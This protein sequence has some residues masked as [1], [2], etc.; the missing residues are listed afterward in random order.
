MSPAERA[1]SAL[2]SFPPGGSHAENTKLGASFK[3]AGGEFADFDAWRAQDAESQGSTYNRAQWRSYDGL[4]VGAGLLFHLATQENDWRDPDPPPSHTNGTG[5]AHTA[6]RDADR[7]APDEDTGERALDLWL[8]GRPAHEHPYVTRKGL[9]AA[10]DADRLR[11]A[12]HDPDCLLVPIRALSDA[13]P[14]VAV[15]RIFA[16]GTKRTLGKLTPFPGC[17]YVIGELRDGV[18]VLACEGMAT[19]E[20]V[21]WA[22]PAAV[23]V[24]TVGVGRVR[25][26]MTEVRERYP[27]SPRVIVADRGRHACDA[28]REKPAD[29]IETLIARAAQE[30]RSAWVSMPAEAAE[31]YDAW[32]FATERGP[33]AL[34]VWIADGGR[35]PYKPRYTGLLPDTV[36]AQPVMHDL[37]DDVIPARSVG[38]IWAVSGAAKTFLALDLA[39]SLTEGAPFF[40]HETFNPVP[41]AIVSLEGNN[42]LPRR[43]RAWVTHNARPMPDTLHTLQQPFSLLNGND[44]DDLCEFIEC[45]GISGGVLII[46]PFAL[47]TLG[48]E[49]NSSADMGNAVAA[50]HTLRDRTGC[51]VIVI[52]HT[53]KDIKNGMRGSSN[54]PYLLDFHIE[55]TRERES[56]ARGWSVGKS[57]EAPDELK[58]EFRLVPVMIGAKPNG[59]PLASCVVENIDAEARGRPPASRPQG[60]PKSANQALAY[61]VIGALLAAGGSLGAGEGCP[62]DRPCVLLETA[63]RAIAEKLFKY[64]EGRRYT[65]AKGVVC[66]MQTKYYGCD[67]NWLW[68]KPDAG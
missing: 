21:A 49:E 64:D 5:N 39:C 3:K 54:L 17:C 14:V 15:Q 27:A 36:M 2:F 43:Y 28:T 58:H 61:D 10:C 30:T 11:V 38:A 37:I 47:A 23:V 62:P 42:G 55:V 20:A 12:A 24:A 16:D 56:G 18:T 8:E 48:L 68:C 31:A 45:A 1:R 66:D 44:V 67:G 13:A 35:H 29:H 32:D 6:T 33:D 34:A 46:D 25:E 41:V 60:K 53:G 19:G 9:R 22:C 65:V 26:V 50:L 4:D 7:G 51:T 59:A 40:G 52:H 63:T 57:K